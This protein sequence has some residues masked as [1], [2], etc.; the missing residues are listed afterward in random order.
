MHTCTCICVCTCVRRCI[1][2]SMHMH[3]CMLFICMSYVY[4]L[5]VCVCVNIYIY[6]FVD[7][8]VVWLYVYIYVWIR[9]ISLYSF[10]AFKSCL[11]CC[12]VWFSEV[13]HHLRQEDGPPEY[14]FF[15]A[16]RTLFNADI[17]DMSGAAERAPFCIETET[18]VFGW[19]I[20]CWKGTWFGCDTI[21]QSGLGT[22][23]PGGIP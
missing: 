17:E 20:G 19:I 10:V 8:D 1:C 18:W 2:M 5:C 6:V 4:V 21:K 14:I 22:S 13:P 16:S 11:S 9:Y 23:F 12:H 3:M 15:S 7:V